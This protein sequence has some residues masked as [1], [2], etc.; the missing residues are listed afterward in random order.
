MTSNLPLK[1]TAYTIGDN[2]D[3]AFIVNI[4]VDGV[5]LQDM[6]I[7]SGAMLINSGATCNPRTEGW[8]CA[9]RSTRMSSVQFNL[10]S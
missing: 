3:D 6:L 2:T 4:S 10:K 5:L 7:D 8:S 9:D 1:M